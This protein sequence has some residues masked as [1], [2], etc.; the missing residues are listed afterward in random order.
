MIDAISRISLGKLP[1]LRPDELY[2]YTDAAALKGILGN[3]TLWASKYQFMND[4]K[5]FLYAVQLGQSIMSNY[6][7]QASSINTRTILRMTLQMMKSVVSRHCFIVSFSKNRDQL[8]QWRAYGKKGGYAIR[9]NFQNLFYYA[10]SKNVRLLECIYRKEEQEECIHQIGSAL[11]SDLETTQHPGVSANIFI[12]KFLLLASII[13]H[14]SF[15]EEAEW[16]LVIIGKQDIEFAPKQ[17]YLLPYVN[18]DLKG[19]SQ[20]HYNNNTYCIEEIMVGPNNKQRLALDSTQLFLNKC[21]VK[22]VKK[23]WKLSS[24]ESSYIIE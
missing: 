18:F 6:L 20:E 16:R 9:F 22:N 5:E 24:S 19:A 13:K 1:E 10:A 7:E 12:E 23:K 14:P 11:I 15:E 2:H 21:N 4:S 17:E 3:G 8:S